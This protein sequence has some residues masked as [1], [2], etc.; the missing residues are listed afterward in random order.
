MFLTGCFTVVDTSQRMTVNPNIK[1]FKIK[2]MFHKNVYGVFAD[3][4]ELMSFSAPFFQTD[5]T[6][7]NWMSKTAF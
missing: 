3:F 4:V 1:N 2:K 5:E 7:K 6:F